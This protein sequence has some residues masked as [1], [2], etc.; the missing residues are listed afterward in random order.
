MRISAD[1]ASSWAPVTIRLKGNNGFHPLGAFY[2]FSLL[3]ISHVGTTSFRG[4]R[5]SC[6]SG[7]FRDST[8]SF[9]GTH[10]GFPTSCLLVPDLHVV[11]PTPSYSAKLPSSET[12]APFLFHSVW[13]S[14][15]SFCH[16]R[17]PGCCPT[18]FPSTL[19]IILGDG[20]DFYSLLN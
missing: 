2:V 1:A 16:L 12:L 9:I 15:L 10:S 4:V 18:D 7:K 5:P 17:I 3:V 20:Y 19:K 6:I 13:Q 14:V 8:E 11:M